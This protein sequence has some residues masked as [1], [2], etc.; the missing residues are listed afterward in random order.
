MTS[1]NR[2]EVWVVTVMKLANMSAAFVT[3]E[4]H[5]LNNVIRVY[6]DICFMTSVNPMLYVESLISV[7]TNSHFTTLLITITP[8]EQASI[9]R[10]RGSSRRCCVTP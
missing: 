4:V 10:V 1:I 5:L 8:D 3:V 9:A 7:T 2:K 6:Y